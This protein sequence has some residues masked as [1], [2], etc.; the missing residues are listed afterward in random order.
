MNAIAVCRLGETGFSRRPWAGSAVAALLAAVAGSAWALD[1]EAAV[2]SSLAAQSAAAA[3]ALERGRPQLEFSA[4]TL[5]R[6]DADGA[7]RSSRIDMTLAPRRS[8]L[9]LSLSMSNNA[10]GPSFAGPR[11]DSGPSVDLG[12]RWRSPLDSN[13]RVDV[14][15]WRRV[16]PA[17]AITLIQTRQ[18]S[19]GARVEMQMPSSSKGLVAERGFIGLQ[20][21]SGARVTVR[22]NFGAPMVYYRSRF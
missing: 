2:A 1:E 21:E 15:A 12:L 8:G 6:F 13:Y 16:M 14:V 9:G 19:Y 3:P 5:P 10:D 17:D 7:S 22:R 11:T 4:S 20:L 18:P